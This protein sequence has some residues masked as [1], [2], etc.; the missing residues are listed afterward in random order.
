MI[1]VDVEENMK[2]EY[3]RLKAEED[4]YVQY[5]R[6]WLNLYAEFKYIV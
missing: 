4:I 3:I 6:I 2:V 5:I 1:M